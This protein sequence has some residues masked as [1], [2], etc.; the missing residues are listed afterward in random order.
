M[1][2]P[3]SQHSGEN[4]L[5]KNKIKSKECCYLSIAYLPY[6]FLF[7]KIVN[8]NLLFVVY[9]HVGTPWL[10]LIPLLCLASGS[11]S[12]RK[13]DNVQIL[14]YKVAPAELQNIANIQ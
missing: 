4:E 3:K 13:E 1:M 5:K 10:C 9:L 11:R 12:R 6:N 14:E 8:V 2:S 7:Y